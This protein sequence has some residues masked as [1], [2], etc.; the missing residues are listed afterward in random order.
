MLVPL[1]L[2]FAALGGAAV[3]SFAGVV[4]TRGLRPSLRG[5]SRCDSCGRSLS[6]WETVPFAGYVAVRGRCRS[7]DARL[8]LTPLLWE[9]GGAAVT[10]AIAAPLALLLTG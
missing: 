10:L 1:T 3:G 4:A 6:W 8:G 5:R 9:A 2:L 7:C